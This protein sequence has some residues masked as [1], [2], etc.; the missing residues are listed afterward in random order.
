MMAGQEYL[1]WFAGEESKRGDASDGI[2]GEECAE[3]TAEWQM[4]I[5]RHAES[6]ALRSKEEPHTLECQNRRQAPTDA[7]DALEDFGKARLLNDVRE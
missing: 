2:S 7:P 4:R 1:G 5:L 6:P 3:R